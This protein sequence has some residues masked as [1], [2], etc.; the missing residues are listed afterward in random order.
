MLEPLATHFSSSITD[1]VK[2]EEEQ[3]EKSVR[4]GESEGGQGE[5]E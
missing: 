4:E 5:G 2:E 3:S 1:P